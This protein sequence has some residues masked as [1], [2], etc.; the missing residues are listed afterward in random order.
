MA[1]LNIKTR[2]FHFSDH[3]IRTKKIT[4]KPIKNNVLPTIIPL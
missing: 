2:L 4:L 3:S 1:I